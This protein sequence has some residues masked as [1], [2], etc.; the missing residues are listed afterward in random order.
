M[1]PDR[2]YRLLLVSTHAVQ[3]ASPVFREMAEHP[4]LEIQVAYCSLQGA[5]GG[6]DKDFGRVVKW[7]VPLLDGY[8]WVQV[9]NHSLHPGLGRFFGLV[10]TGL[11]RM[12]RR[13][14]YDAILVYTGYRYLSFWIALAAAKLTGTPILF[15][16]DAATL[17]PRSGGGWKLR[18]KRRFWPLLFGM[19]DQVIVP[20]TPTQEMIRSLGVPRERISLTPYVVDNDWWR[21]QAARIDRG[22]VRDAWHMPQGA[23]VVLFCAKLQPWKR[24]MDLLQAFAKMNSLDCFLVYAGDGQLHDDLRCKA[25]KLGV[26]ERVRF[27]GFVNQSQLPSVYRASD[28]LVLPSEHEPFGVVVNEAMLCGCAVGV[29]N[30]VGAGPDLIRPENGFVFPCGDVD[31]LTDQL[32]SATKNKELLQR[33]GEASQR[34]ME[35]WSPRENIQAVIDAVGRAVVVRSKKKQF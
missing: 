9:P 22:K 26:A 30:R 28:L 32:R 17:D 19:A 4:R 18:M 1:M 2:P 31:A 34:R 15:G 14:Q 13:G 23:T 3:Y 7:D 29:S 6:I 24:P 16:T 25:E 11:W 20:S 33:M 5:E 27:L 21:D 35:T 12:I 10:N 8:P